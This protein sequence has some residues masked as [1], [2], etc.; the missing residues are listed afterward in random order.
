MAAI[1]DRIGQPVPAALGPASVE[2]A[3]TVGHRHGSFSKAC[4]LPVTDRGQRRDVI[5]GEAAGLRKDRVHDAVGDV[6]PGVGRAGNQSQREQDFLDR[7]LVDWPS[8]VR[9]KATKDRC[10]GTGA[11]RPIAALAVMGCIREERRPFATGG[12]RKFDRLSP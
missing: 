10:C 4:A 1:F 11:A 7:C 2:I 5:L 6:C 9:V 12:C 8:P 3:P